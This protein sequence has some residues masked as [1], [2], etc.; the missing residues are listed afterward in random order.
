MTSDS[1]FR[2]VMKICIGGDHA[3]YEIQTLNFMKFVIICEYG[4]RFE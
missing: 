2:K 4:N 1:V 3:G